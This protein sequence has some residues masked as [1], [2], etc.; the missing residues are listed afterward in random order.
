MKNFLW[1][2]NCLNFTQNYSLTN[3]GL[4]T[5]GR[6]NH[7]LLIYT[8]QLPFTKVMLY[9]LNMFITIE[10]TEENNHPFIQVHNWANRSTNHYIQLQNVKYRLHLN[11]ALMDSGSSLLTISMM[12][13]WRVNQIH[14]L[15]NWLT[16]LNSSSSSSDQQRMANNTDNSW[17][18]IQCIPLLTQMLKRKIRVMIIN[19]IIIIILFH[20]YLNCKLRWK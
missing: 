18:E 7:Q 2:T 14:R 5:T 11:R 16:D 10:E 1:F 13:T 17:A 12:N 19:L 20:T 8:V 6:I 4:W 9:N 3:Y 15:T